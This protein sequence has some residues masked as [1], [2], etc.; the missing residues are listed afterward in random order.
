MDQEQILGQVIDDNYQLT[1][2]IGSGA[3]STVYEATHLQ[4]QRPVAIKIMHVHLTGSDDTVARFKREG[5]LTSNLN[6]PN[7]A[8][9][10]ASGITERRQPYLVMERLYGRTLSERLTE[11]PLSRHEFQVVATALGA[12]LKYAHEQNVVH[13][14]IKPSNIFVAE[15]FTTVKLLDFGIA[16]I[17][18]DIDQRL[19][20]TG[21]LV[22]S[23]AY[24]SP[25]QL[26]ARPVDHRA[27]IFSL[28]RV[29]KEC[30][31]GKRD[32]SLEK[33][34]KES[35]AKGT[36][37]MDVLDRF[38]AENP[39]DRYQS[40][41]AGISDL[42]EALSKTNFATRR[43]LPPRPAL[44]MVAA[45]AAVLLIA[46]AASFF[47]ADT[48]S[49]FL[50]AQK[51]YQLS[52]P[53]RQMRLRLAP[54]SDD[55]QN[56]LYGKLYTD[57]ALDYQ[58]SG[59]FE[60]AA[61]Y[62]KRAIDELARGIETEPD[63]AIPAKLKPQLDLITPSLIKVLQVRGGGEYP[64]TYLRDDY[65]VLAVD[66]GRQ[67][68]YEQ[69]LQYFL[70]RLKIEEQFPNQYVS[71]AEGYWDVAGAYNAL[72]DPLRALAYIEKA[73][74]T[75][76]KDPQA[77]IMHAES[78]ARKALY[79]QTLKRDKE[80][81]DL[82]H[83]CLDSKRFETEPVAIGRIYQALAE[84]H[85][86]LKQWQQSTDYM[87]RAIASFGSVPQPWRVVDCTRELSEI[88]IHAGKFD[89]ALPYA[90][91]AKKG[92]AEV[93]GFNTAQIMSNRFDLAL[94]L[95]KLGRLK[96]SQEMYRLIVEQPTTWPA[97]AKARQQ[98]IDLYHDYAEKRR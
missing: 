80:A 38:T 29:L 22:G 42:E 47:Y 49:D 34:S 8:Q 71:L 95:L 30:W 98:L 9:V 97:D 19:T 79:L 89:Q 60:D 17:L 27:D 13:R 92:I 6:H 72:G 12:A 23:L 83:S 69:Q 61:A 26:K 45:T 25:E 96:E 52:I 24:M 84:Y 65:I 1:A 14:D 55:S 91:K 64:L 85:R 67:G 35:R 93:E 88:Y 44:L 68:T 36:E 37:L 70:V 56:V 31:T 63:N 66:E 32:I 81:H 21:A 48:I 74:V 40:V 39:E 3:S 77:K 10:Y 94:C 62:R 87:K 90:E 5:Q 20:A 76:G 54:K 7:I 16:K 53:L 43:Q 15:K 46:A 2:V 51:L 78:F 28:G 82:L 57:L 58:N 18:G 4:M 86:Q 73:V 59:N 33:R 50:S 11:G 75:F 41:S